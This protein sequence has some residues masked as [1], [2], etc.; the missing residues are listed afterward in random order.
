MQR[1]LFWSHGQDTQIRR[2][3]V[4]GASWET[5]AAELSLPLRAVTARAHRLGLARAPL[6]GR[7]PQDPLR[8]A[9]PAGHP[10]SWGAI[11]S[12]TVLEGQLYPL[13]Y[14]RR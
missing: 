10:E 12:G 8:E 6:P 2:R 3:R 13:R 11:T 5:I 1:K 4:E 7:P 14:F 9:L